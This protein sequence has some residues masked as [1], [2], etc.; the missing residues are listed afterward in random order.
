MLYDPE[1]FPGDEL[2]E[3]QLEM[4]A[5][6]VKKNPHIEPLVKEALDLFLKAIKFDEPTEEQMD[7]DFVYD[8]HQLAARYMNESLLNMHTAA[9]KLANHFDQEQVIECCEWLLTSYTD[10]ACSHDRKKKEGN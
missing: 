4:V 5:E 3:E 6:I 7:Q 2:L 9:G 10:R 8:D 1:L